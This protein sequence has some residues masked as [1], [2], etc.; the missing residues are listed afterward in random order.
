AWL[1]GFG[2]LGLLASDLFFEL[3]LTYST[4]RSGTAMDIGWIVFFAAWGLAA[5]HPSMT[6]I[7]RPVNTYRAAQISRVGFALLAAA[8]LTAPAVLLGAALHGTVEQGW[9]LAGF[10]ALSSALVLIRLGLVLRSYRRAINR[11]RVVRAAG[12]DLVA[13]LGVEQVGVALDRAGGAL[14]G[15]Q[16]GRISLLADLSE[17]LAAARSRPVP[18]EQ[19]PTVLAAGAAVGLPDT[20]HALVYP[21]RVKRTDRRAGVVAVGPRDDL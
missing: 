12:T 18:V 4:W 19:L 6:R 17:P 3:R 1:L 9:V 15:P 7:G 11:S 8:T 10:A 20:T 14:L 5:L 2:T 13:A 21:L 16:Q